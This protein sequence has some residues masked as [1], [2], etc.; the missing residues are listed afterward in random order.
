MMFRL[1]CVQVQLTNEM[2]MLLW[3]T[4]AGCCCS[5]VACCCF[6]LSRG[7]RDFALVRTLDVF[8]GAAWWSP[9]SKKC[10]TLRT[11]FGTLDEL[12]KIF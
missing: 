8:F 3:G 1:G 9:C 10:G 12:I 2:V 6:G 4:Q 7:R 5:A 11:V